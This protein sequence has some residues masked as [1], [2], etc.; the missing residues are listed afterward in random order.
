LGVSGFEVA[1]QFGPGVAAGPVSGWWG[2]ELVEM[3]IQGT[4]AGLGHA[5]VCLPYAHQ[6]ADEVFAAAFGLEGV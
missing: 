4:M 2:A 5:P 1:A 3:R 6:G